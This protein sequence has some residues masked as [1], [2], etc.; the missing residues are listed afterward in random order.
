MSAV[1]YSCI[2]SCKFKLNTLLGTKAMALE[3]KS[4]L[5]KNGRENI[6]KQIDIIKLPVSIQIVLLTDY[7]ISSV[8]NADK[9]F[10]LGSLLE[11]K[12]SM[13]HAVE[14]YFR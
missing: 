11:Y 13:R 10:N 8:Y 5:K 1:S 2:S 6:S 14:W 9:G 3:D 7:H 12:G 4:P